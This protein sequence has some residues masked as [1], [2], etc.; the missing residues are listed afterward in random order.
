MFSLAAAFSN[1]RSFV[2]PFFLSRPEAYNEVYRCHWFA[3]LSAPLLTLKREHISKQ[4][5]VPMR[6]KRSASRRAAPRALSDELFRVFVDS[7]ENCA[8]YTMDPRGRIAS[9]NQGAE[10]LKGYTAREIIGRNYSCFFTQEDQQAGKPAKFLRLAAQR[11]R[12]EEESL[13]VRKD[14]SQFWAGTVLTAIKDSTGRLLG[15]AKVTRDVTARIHADE[16]LRHANAELAAE[17]RR[18]HVSERELERSSVS[19]RELSHRLLRAQDEERRR[20]GRELHDSLGQYLSMLK[21][22][23]ESLDLSPQRSPGQVAAQVARC[24]RLAEDSLKEVRTVSHLLYPPT[25]E[26]MGL[27][28]AFPWYLDGFSRRSD[29]Q[30]TLEMDNDFPRLSTDLEVALFRVLQEGLNNVHR[31]SGSSKAFIRLYVRRE[32][33]NLEIRDQGKGI[34]PV[35]LDDWLKDASGSQGVG[36]RSMHERMRQLGGDLALTSGHHGTEIRATVPLEL[37]VAASGCSTT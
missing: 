22:H 35:V 28:S 18:R 4:R 12:A 32:R 10:R 37:A 11:G 7:V 15:F 23:L 24:V 9:W 19:L 8:I 5:R 14:G 34:S 31:H 16:D 29:I 13:R 30:T 2:Q 27:K 17:I 1:L 33:V 36:L 3:S 25:L 6:S 21:M 26:E 20:I